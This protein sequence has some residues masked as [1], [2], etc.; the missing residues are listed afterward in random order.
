MTRFIMSLDEAIDLVLYA[1]SYGEKGDIYVKKSPACNVGQ[2]SKVIK[3]L[4]NKDNHEEVIIGPR[5]GEKFHEVLISKEE[6]SRATEKNGFYK[7]IP[8]G[9]NLEYSKYENHG[10]KDINKYS[11]YNSKDSEQLNYQS[12]KNILRDY[13]LEK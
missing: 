8:D 6:L 13:V 7:I 5:H 9:R 10:D 11:E 3:N 4:L 12:L 1:L 2:I